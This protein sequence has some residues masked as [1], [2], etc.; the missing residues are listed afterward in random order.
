M[1]PRLPL[2]STIV[3]VAACSLLTACGGGEPSESDIKS[4]VEKSVADAGLKVLSVK[5]S[6]CV[7]AGAGYKCTFAGKYQTDLGGGVSGE[8]TRETLFVKTASGWTVSTAR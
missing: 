2:V 7:D 4:A 5:K 6:K 8:E 1:L 3:L